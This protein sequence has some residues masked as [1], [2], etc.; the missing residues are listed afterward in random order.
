MDR[1]AVITGASRGVGAATAVL[2]AQRRLRV[3]VNYRSSSEEADAVVETVK[4]AGG[5]AWAIR[6]DVTDPDDVASMFSETERR[7]GHVDVLVHNAL[8]PYDVTSFAD[9][10][11]EQLGGKVEGAAGRINTLCREGRQRTRHW[12]RHASRVVRRRSGRDRSPQR[13]GPHC[14]EAYVWRNRCRTRRQSRQ[15]RESN[16]RTTG[17][18][19]QPDIER[20]SDVQQNQRDKP[21]LEHVSHS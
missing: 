8:M 18:D 5:E 6:A 19:G 1:V 15:H 12:S 10:S 21:R 3:V 17:P 16:K 2:L 4:A 7:W 13:D 20:G 11:W 9:L 14:C